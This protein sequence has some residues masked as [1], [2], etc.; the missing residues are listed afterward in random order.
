MEFGDAFQDFK[1]FK[2]FDNLLKQR[3]SFECWWETMCYGMNK[4]HS[5]KNKN[6][7]N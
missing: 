4:S 5:S 6:N 2:T 1:I 3:N 7:N